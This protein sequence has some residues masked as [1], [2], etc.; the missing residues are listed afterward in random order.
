MTEKEQRGREIY[1]R[2]H[3][4]FNIAPFIAGWNDYGLPVIDYEKLA[5]NEFNSMKRAEPINDEPIAQIEWKH[6][7]LIGRLI[8]R[9]RDKD[10]G[11]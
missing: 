9:L 8:R 4:A 10:G 7:G 3:P 5:D 11:E 2:L 1:A 6:V